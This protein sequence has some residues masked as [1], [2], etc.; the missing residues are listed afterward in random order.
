MLGESESDSDEMDYSVADND[1][2]MEMQNERS[3][4][5]INFIDDRMLASMD[6]CKITDR[7]AM[8]LVSAT[9]TAVLNKMQETQ[10]EW[11]A[12]TIDDLVL[13]RTSIQSMRKGYRRRQA[14]EIVDSFNVK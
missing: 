6:R 1:Y 3:R 2:H 8:H 13:N 9:A 10:P 11:K 4:K 5:K 14:Q 12:V 7:D